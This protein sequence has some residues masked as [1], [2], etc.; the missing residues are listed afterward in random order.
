MNKKIS[1]LLAS[2]LSVGALFTSCADLDSDKYFD[3]RVT[4]ES[5]FTDYN[6][7]QQ[8]LAQAYSWLNGSNIE[9]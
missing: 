9:V 1:I 2:V 4:L 7:A 6:E 5:V 3:D 8:W